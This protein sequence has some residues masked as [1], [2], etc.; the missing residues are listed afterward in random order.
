MNY[1]KQGTLKSDSIQVTEFLNNVNEN[2]ILSDDESFL[3][4]NDVRSRSENR[5][6]IPSNIEH[7]IDYSIIE[8][9][10][11]EYTN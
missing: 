11:V 8:E 5:K 3:S 1:K 2:E 10:K 4:N 7:S 9:Y 6:N